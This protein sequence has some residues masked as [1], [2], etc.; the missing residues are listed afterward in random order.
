MLEEDRVVQEGRR[1]VRQEVHEVVLQEGR[2]GG[3]R[4]GV[5]QE[6]RLV[7]QADARVRVE[8]LP[9]PVVPEA[10][11]P[12]RGAVWGVSLVAVVGAALEVSEQVGVY[13]G[14]EREAVLEL[15]L[16]VALLEAVIW[17]PRAL[18]MVILLGGLKSL[19]SLPV[20]VN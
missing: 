8:G 2:E 4:L 17:P 15:A 5:L 1:E 16:V 12:E 11:L 13:F 10:A 14:L 3:R 7:P 6:G 20:V 9:L 18:G 19:L